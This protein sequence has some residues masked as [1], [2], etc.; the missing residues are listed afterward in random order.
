MNGFSD[1]LQFVAHARGSD[2][3]ASDRALVHRAQHGDESAFAELYARYRARVHLFLGAALDRNAVED[4]AQEVFTRAG[5]ALA[6]FDAARP[7]KPWLFG[8]ARYVAVDELR[9]RARIETWDPAAITKRHDEF[10][11]AGEPH[12]E[13]AAGKW[14]LRELAPLVRDLAPDQRKVFVLVPVLGYSAEEAGRLLGK[15]PENVRKLKSRALAALK[16][17]GGVTN[18]RCFSNK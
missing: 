14:A 4:A 1:R 5:P 16:K 15:T 9:D 8:I 6:R 7:L 12:S 2:G 17:K 11:C 18:G 10:A 13:L 3:D